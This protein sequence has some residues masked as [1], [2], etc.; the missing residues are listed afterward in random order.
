MYTC[1]GWL[2][3]FCALWPKT[4]SCLAGSV[5]ESAS[6]AQGGNGLGKHKGIWLI[7]GGSAVEE[8]MHMGCTE[9]FLELTLDIMDTYPTVEMTGD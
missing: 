8:D 9:E 5:C 2:A 1:G 7:T 4:A 3:E 6:G